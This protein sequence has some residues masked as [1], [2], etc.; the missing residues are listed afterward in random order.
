MALLE[1]GHILPH[2]GE[3][4]LTKRLS[5]L[6]RTL[7]S[8]LT[9]SQSCRSGAVKERRCYDDCFACLILEPGTRCSDEQRSLVA[10]GKETM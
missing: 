2:I 6:F 10:S 3:V 9:V 1:W 4:T 7:G 5:A 8:L